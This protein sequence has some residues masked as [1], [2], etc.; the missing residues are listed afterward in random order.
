MK[1][2]SAAAVAAL[3]T[4]LSTA[5]GVRAFQQQSALA[6]RPTSTAFVRSTN[7]LQSTVTDDA[8]CATPDIDVPKGVTAKLLRSA[9]LTN[10]DGES[11]SLGDK[12]GPGTSV[13]VFLRH[14]G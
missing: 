3:A 8:P 6:S 1:F 13:V 12:M 11:V 2:L 14:L 5:G 4:V 7:L 10:A 9:V